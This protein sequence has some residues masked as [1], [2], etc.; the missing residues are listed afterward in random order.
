[1]PEGI[2]NLGAP[3]N[4]PES[5]IFDICNEEKALAV[6]RPKDV[7]TVGN[8]S[9]GN[10]MRGRAA[11]RPPSAINLPAVEEADASG[12]VAELY[13]RYR[14]H[15]GRPTVPGILKCFATHPVLLRNMMGLAEGML[16]VDGSLTRRHKEMIATVVSVENTCSY[17]ADSHGYF[18]RTLGGSAEQLAAIEA[19]DL[20]S[21]AFSPQERVLLAFVDKVTR[22]SH[23]VHRG[24]VEKLIEIG[25]SEPQIAETIHVAALFATFNR[26]VNAFGLPSQH[27]LDLYSGQNIEAEPGPSNDP[28]SDEQP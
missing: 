1:M 26:I 27:L 4:L 17:C 25:W 19:C 11:S 18:L 7:G 8:G 6:I 12:E 14:S 5:S 3:F 16:F 15:F 22:A 2:P 23:S 9:D 21:A 24:D 28:Q 10:D 20:T 13:E